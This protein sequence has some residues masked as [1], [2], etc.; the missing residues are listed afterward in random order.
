MAWQVADAKAKFSE[1][2]DTAATRPQVVRR[3]KQ[4]YVITTEEE[5]E[6]RLA[7]ARAGKRT[8]FVSAWEALGGPGI[9]DEKEFEEFSA[10][11]REARG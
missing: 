1:L 10:A 3:R 2:L 9:L 8:K 6:K 7:E 11:L 4:S 5:I